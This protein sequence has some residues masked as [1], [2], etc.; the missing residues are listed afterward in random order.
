MQQNEVVPQ[1]N[2][3]VCSSA[4]TSL[5]SQC[6]R[7]VEEQVLSVDRQ[8]SSVLPN[9]HELSFRVWLI[10][11]PEASYYPQC[12]ASD[13][14]MTRK[15]WLTIQFVL[16]AGSFPFKP[17]SPV[18]I[19]RIGTWRYLFWRAIEVQTW[20]L[21]LYIVKIAVGEQVRGI[22]LLWFHHLQ[23]VSCVKRTFLF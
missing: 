21:L 19:L 17:K 10:I 23:V 6:F 7:V 16:S 12:H 8:V 3:P 22:L 18:F 4:V 5:F 1:R 14:I 9:K 15:H 13:V 11:T 20:S 2:T